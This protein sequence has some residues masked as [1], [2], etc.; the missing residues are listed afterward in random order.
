MEIAGMVTTVPIRQTNLLAHLRHGG[1]V[2]I[3]T[4]VVHPGVEVVQRVHDSQ[5]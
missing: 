3:D 5:T 2:E 1:Y 4:V